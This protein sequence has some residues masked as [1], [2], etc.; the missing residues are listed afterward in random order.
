[1]AVRCPQCGGELP[2]LLTACKTCFDL[3]FKQQQALGPVPKLSQPRRPSGC[4]ARKQQQYVPRPRS[5]AAVKQEET[6]PIL[7]PSELEISSYIQSALDTYSI[8][9]E[10]GVYLETYEG[11]GIE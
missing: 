8:E 10:T 7:T 2:T 4:A 1:M 9:E 5:A 11:S 3:L 6:K